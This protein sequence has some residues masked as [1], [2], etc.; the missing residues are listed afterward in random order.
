MFL[1][2]G[3]VQGLVMGILLWRDPGTPGRANRW[4]AVLLWLFAYRLGVQLLREQELTGVHHWSYYFLLEYTWVYGSLIFGYTRSL[5]RPEYPLQ[6]GDLWLWVPI[7]LQFIFS[8]FIKWQNWF[9]DGSRESLTWAGYEGYRLWVHTPFE[10]GTAM[11]LVVYFSFRSLRLI[12]IPQA[13]DRILQARF[14]KYL[15]Q[16]LHLYLLYALLVISVTLI[17]YLFYDFAFHPQYMYPVYIG[18][19][20]ITYWLGLNALLQRNLSIFVKPKPKPTLEDQNLARAIEDLMQKELLYRKPDLKVADLAE[21][22]NTKAFRVSRA[23]NSVQMENFSDYI[24]SLRITEVRQRIKDPA[25]QHLTLLALAF[26]AGFNSKASFN[27][28]AKKLTGQSPSEWLEKRSQ[29]RN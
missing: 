18:L 21:A 4:L 3:A 8:N 12:N 2:L 5:L 10:L 24:N 6:K 9:W 13:G 27:R 15:K 26:E 7:V 17:D 19:A 20:L 11:A 16:T 23:L 22:L 25:Y 29:F 28:A 1:F 14:R